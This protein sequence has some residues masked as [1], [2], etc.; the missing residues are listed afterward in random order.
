MRK[1]PGNRFP[2]EVQGEKPWPPEATLPLAARREKEWVPKPDPRPTHEKSP[3]VSAAKKQRLVKISEARFLQQRPPSPQPPREAPLSPKPAV[4]SCRWDKG[5]PGE[6]FCWR[7]AVSV[8]VCL[9]GA[10]LLAVRCSGFAGKRCLLGSGACL[11]VPF[12]HGWAGGRVW[13]PTLF[14]FAPLKVKIKTVGLCPT[15]CRGK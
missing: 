6:A 1:G 11:A 7:S 3:P 4:R 14:L 8:G 5:P 9:W 12:F 15:L 2:G 13:G 10:A